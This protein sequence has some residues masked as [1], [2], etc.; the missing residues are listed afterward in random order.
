M[1]EKELLLE[2]QELKT[3]FFTQRGVVRAVNGVSFALHRGQALGRHAA[4]HRD[5][6]RL[7]SPRWR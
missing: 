2:V 3:Y 5:G 7:R 6:P 4:G 1:P